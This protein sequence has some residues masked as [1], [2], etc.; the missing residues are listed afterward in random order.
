RQPGGIGL[1]G[2]EHRR[3]ARIAAAQRD[4]RDVA[5]AV[6][7][8][9][10]DVGRVDGDGGGAALLIGDEADAAHALTALSAAVRSTRDVIEIAP[11][12]APARLTRLTRVLRI[13]GVNRIIDSIDDA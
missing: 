12:V 9:P 1:I 10:I 8:D 13:R 6:R 3:A 2:G 5:R 7:V 4:L 11:R